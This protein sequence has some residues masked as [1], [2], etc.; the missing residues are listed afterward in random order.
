MPIKVFWLNR[1]LIVGIITVQTEEA[2]EALLKHGKEIESRSFVSV[3]NTPGTTDRKVT[4]LSTTESEQT[5]VFENSALLLLV[6]F[7]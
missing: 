5:S 2:V 7:F 4:L 1:T 6:L 3:H